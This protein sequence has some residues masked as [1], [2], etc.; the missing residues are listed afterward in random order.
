MLKILTVPNAILLQ[1]SVEVVVID[2]KIK[3]L[4]KEMKISLSAQKDPE[5]VGLAAVQIGKLLRICIIKPTLRGKV[6]TLINPVITQADEPMNEKGKYT[7]D[8]LEGCLSIPRYW[9]HVGRSPRIVVSYLNEEGVSE[10][11]E[12][13]KFVASVVQHEMDHMD[14]ILFT[15]RALQQNS[16]LYVEKGKDLV[17]VRTL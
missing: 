3:D 5:G 17:P 15:Q 7:N 16:I 14:G 2:K 8:Q 12:F 6:L 4:V 9:A 13:K 10:E 11:R 1:K